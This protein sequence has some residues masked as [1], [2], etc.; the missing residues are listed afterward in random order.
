VITDRQKLTTKITLYGIL[1]SVFTV[2]INSKS[3][4]WPVHS[5][6]E[7]SPNFLRHTMRVDNTQIT[8][9]SLSCRQPSPSTIESRDTT[10]RR[11][12]EVNSLCTDSRAL[13]SNTVLWAFHTI[14]P[15]SLLPPSPLCVE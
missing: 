4:P 13:Q 5:V 15:P 7:T 11:M 9:T 6:Q 8:L 10:S 12:Q 1:V 14:Q 2:G 3:F